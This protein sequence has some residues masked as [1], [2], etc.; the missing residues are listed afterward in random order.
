MLT[1]DIAQFFSFLN[2]QLLL[3]IL[4]KTSFDLRI[5]HLFSDFLFNKQ[6]QYIW[7]YFVFLFFEANVS[8]GQN[9]AF[10]PILSVLYIA[11]I[12]HIF[13]KRTKNIL[14]SIQVLT[15]SFVNGRL[16]ISQEKSYE[17]SNAN[18]FCSYTIISSLFNQFRL[19]IEHSKLEVFYFS[20]STKYI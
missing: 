18:L 17:K 6:T 4:D 3:K 11:F 14:F 7:N 19:V 8:I 15:F 12:F 10:S 9:S 16:F 13:E 20:R 2:Y 5:S 1:F